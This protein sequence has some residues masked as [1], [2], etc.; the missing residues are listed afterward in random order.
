MRINKLL[1]LTFLIIASC[2]G[3]N[4]D[5]IFNLKSGK[6]VSGKI[7][8][9]ADSITYI[10][11]E[12]DTN[13]LIKDVRQLEIYQNRIF[14]RNGDQDLFVFSITGKFLNKI[15]TRGKGPGE[16]IHA[17]GFTVDTV[18]QTIFLLDNTRIVGYDYQGNFTGLEI[19]LKNHESLYF[20]E[21]HLY[22]YTPPEVLAYS[23]HKSCKLEVINLKGEIINSY[24]PS[25]AKKGAMF[26]TPGTFYVFNNQL[27]FMDSDESIF[28]E[29]NDSSIR[30]KYAFYY[31]SKRRS[32]LEHYPRGKVFEVQHLLEFNDSIL[33]VYDLE[34][35]LHLSFC[36][37]ITG[38]CY[39]VNNNTDVLGF[40]DDIKGSVPIYPR[41]QMAK[42]FI[43][44]L[45]PEQEIPGNILKEG[46]NP[47]LRLVFLKNTK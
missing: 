12:T 25:F 7:S 11:L 3:K 37:K 14:V 8:R 6:S 34:N 27:Y 4:K 24:L 2:T 19:P 38:K 18:H 46:D 33:V 45:Y 10:K 43:D 15:G 17:Y 5:V 16:Y 32:K 39:N 30:Q 9:I 35:R 28:Y 42:G 1:F 13:C 36:N 41:L 29:L 26:I 21:D 31:G 40:E 20:F 44:V 22:T 47:L 23:D